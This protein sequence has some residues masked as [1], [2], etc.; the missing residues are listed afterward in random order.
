MNIKLT[1][2]I[3]SKTGHPL[4]IEID[5]TQMDYKEK[6]LPMLQE[7]FQSGRSWRWALAKHGLIIDK[8]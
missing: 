8:Q 4:E 6:I 1:N 3:D 2:L 7:A 5:E